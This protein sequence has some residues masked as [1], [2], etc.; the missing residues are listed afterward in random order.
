MSFKIIRSL[1]GFYPSFHFGCEPRAVN[2]T[3]SI[4]EGFDGKRYLKTPFACLNAYAEDD[5]ERQ[6]VILNSTGFPSYFQ[7]E[8]TCLEYLQWA[9]PW[10]KH[11]E[12]IME[13]L[14]FTVERGHGNGA[15]GIADKC[16]CS[17]DG[18][19]GIYQF[20]R[21]YRRFNLIKIKKASKLF[22]RKP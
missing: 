6:F 15:L 2:C 7:D 16:D 17:L 5:I 20:A 11:A 10:W 9:Y 22:Q 12:P 18:P 8:K 13:A 19:M 1:D 4:I 21:G 14:W 3:L